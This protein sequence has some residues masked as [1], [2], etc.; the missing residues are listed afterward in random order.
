MDLYYFLETDS[1][2]C[3]RNVACK[4]VWQRSAMVY[5]YSIPAQEKK[6]TLNNL[7]L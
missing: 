4:P 1:S 5:V 2:S 7:E 6:E 3:Q